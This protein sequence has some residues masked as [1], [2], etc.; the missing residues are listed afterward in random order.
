MRLTKSFGK[1]LPSSQPFTELTG[2]IP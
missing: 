2:K 1:R